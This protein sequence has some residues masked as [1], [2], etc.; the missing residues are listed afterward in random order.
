MIGDRVPSTFHG[1]DIFSPAAAHLAAG[2]DWTLAGPSV[3]DLVRLRSRSAV[4]AEKGILGEV[5][6]LDDP[7]GNLITDIPGDALKQLGWM[8]G[9][10]IGIQIGKRGYT[11]PY[12]KTF[13]EVPAGHP[14]LYIDSRGRVA[15]TLNQGDFAATYKIAPAVPFF[16]PRKAGKAPSAR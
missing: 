1:R 16:I 4:T 15:V 13:S 3:T 7:Y 12:A 14:L 5:I 10:N 11:I 8:P 9:E 6:G 2:E